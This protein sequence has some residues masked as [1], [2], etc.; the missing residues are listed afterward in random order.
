MYNLSDLYVSDNSKV[1]EAIKAINKT[2]AYIALV[3]DKDKRL[4]G[5]ITDGD[6]RRGLL[7]GETLNSN[8]S[9]FMKQNFFS[10][11]E[12][13]LSRTNIEEIFKRVSDSDKPKL[14]TVIGSKNKADAKIA[15]ITPAV[16]I[17]SGK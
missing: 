16:L 2:R 5:T 4:I 10:I 9:K 1:I 12:G 14:D 7:N 3:V 8:V 17:F 11:R 13:D 15:G 6:I